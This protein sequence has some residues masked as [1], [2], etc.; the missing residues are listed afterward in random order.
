MPVEPTLQLAMDLIG[1]PSVTPDDAGCQPL[2][3]DR[4]AARHCTVR[5]LRFEEVS[6][7]WVT[8][9]QGAPLL[10]LLGH[11]DVVPPGP[12]AA[13]ESDPFQ[14]SLRGELLYGR[15]AA[16]MKG[17]VAA[18]V[19]ALER[20]VQ[21]FPQHGGTAA[22]LLTS[23]EEGRAL[24]GT[25]RVAQWLRQQ[26]IGPDYCLVGEPSSRERLG[27][28]IK[29]GRRG[30][31]GGRLLIRGKQGH[32]AYPERAC[33]PI[34]SALP[35][36][37]ELCGVTW[38][39]GDEHFPPTGFQFSNV[40]AGVGADNVIPDELT[41][42][43]NFRYSPAIDR[44]E[45][46]RRFGALLKAHALRFELEWFHSAEPFL[47]RSGRL[48]ETTQSAVRETVGVEAELST[49]GGTSD[50]RFFAAHG[51]EVLELGPLNGSIHQVNEHV[52][53]AD[54]AVLA[55]IYQ[56]ILRGLLGA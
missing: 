5:H 20:F 27:D 7:L 37:S 34:H 23:D 48:L 29:N 47:T 8:H 54:L 14:P 53:A 26:G 16:D 11:T 42:Q 22:L 32:V 9:G 38:D 50:G 25:R 10:V 35:A 33:N 15:G 6:N 41:V 40:Q 51:T 2:V 24:H 1:R 49:E 56:R 45:L 52:R 17:S 12:S 39:A 19:I 18:M 44:E 55:E 46:Q 36:L 13:W 28:V 3:A 30:S 4:L 21:E 31:L 43:F